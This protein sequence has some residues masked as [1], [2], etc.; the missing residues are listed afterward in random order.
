MRNE[1]ERSWWSFL[2]LWIQARSSSI[3]FHLE[4]PE[5]E[6]VDTKGAWN[7]NYNNL[8]K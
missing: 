2:L 8:Y 7:D 3:I 4:E 6:V 5:E 1:K